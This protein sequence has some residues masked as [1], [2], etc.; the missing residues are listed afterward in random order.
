M[1]PQT[2]QVR[3]IAQAVL[4]EGYLLWPYR[5]S[6]LKNRH[7]WTIGG[8]HPEAYGRAHDGNHWRMRTE[9]LVEA[10]P[11]DTVDVCVR[12][13]H[14]VTREP[15]AG[16][17]G[18]RSGEEARER[19]LTMP[20]LVVDELVH[21]PAVT[22]IDLPAGRRIEPLHEP[23]TG[24]PTE[25]PTGLP[26]ELPAGLSTGLST[27][28]PTGAGGQAGMVVRSWEALRGRIE[29]SARRLRPGL[30][31]ITVEVVNTT[32]WGPGTRA[33]ALRRT[34]A[35]AHTVLHG[36]RARF[37]SLMD[38]PPELREHAEACRNEGAWPV[39]AGPHG[40]RHTVL[41]SPI[42]LYDH[43]EI[44]P[45]SPGD[46]FDNT[47]IDQLLTLSVLAL[48]DQERQEIRDGDPR[49]RAILDRCTA[50]APEDLVRL[51]GLMRRTEPQE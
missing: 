9:C 32:P 11:G 12:F 28:P 22:A 42:I 19:E 48:S 23:P 39:L 24:P 34:L 2:D 49:A 51:H 36:P 18:R 45:E 5:E 29:A 3:Q 26:T 43:P 27:G 21:G 14:V 47:E 46:L 50:L 6:S 17:P 13:L 38:P 20:G 40:D 25:L 30:F 44:A 8:V 37:V 41:A 4:Y 10:E 16:G 1:H 15:V 7:R 31:T 33:D 35:S